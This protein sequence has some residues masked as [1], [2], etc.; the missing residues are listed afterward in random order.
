ML[1]KLFPNLTKERYAITSPKTIEYNCI[2][3]AFDDTERW[4]WPDPYYQYYWPSDIPRVE[5]I[6]NFVKAFEK[7][8]YIACDNPK[9]EKGFEKVAIYADQHGKPTHA[10]RQLE[11]GIWTSKLGKLEDISHDID[12]ISCD[13]YGNVVIVLKRAK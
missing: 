6:E 10:A 2:A 11:P 5:S 3:W 4:W 8:G 13:L 1:E 12:G 7:L 9:F